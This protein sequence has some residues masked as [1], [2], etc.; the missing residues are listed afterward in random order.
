MHVTVDG[1]VYKVTFS[2]RVNDYLKKKGKGYLAVCCK[3]VP[4]ELADQT[5]WEFC[6]LANRVADGDIN[7][8]DFNDIEWVDNLEIAH[9]MS[10]CD[11]DLYFF[12]EYEAV[13]YGEN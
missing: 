5:T 1:S 3:I 2:E 9:Y 4:E 8:K 11:D 12:G 10:V 7:I 13:E 6:E